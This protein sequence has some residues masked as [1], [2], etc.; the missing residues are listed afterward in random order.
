MARSAQDV[1]QAHA[2]ALASGDLPKIMEDYSADAV[3][4]TPEG[5][6][7][8]RD[9]ISDFFAAALANL[10]DAEFEVRTAIFSDDALLLRW[11]ASS[12][13]NRIA[14]AVDTFVFEQGLIRLHSTV[15]SVEP[16]STA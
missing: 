12:S 1:F 3:L 7:H 9:A 13:T 6:I 5:P 15:F 16:V 4:L 2:V 8:G 14:D 10:P 11:S